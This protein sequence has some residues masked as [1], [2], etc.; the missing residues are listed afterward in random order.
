[1]A[2]AVPVVAEQRRRASL[3]GVFVSWHLLSL[4]APTVAVLWAWAFARAAH[5][6]AASGAIAVLGIGTWLIYVADRLLD[7][8]DGTARTALRERHR[9]H[10]KHRRPFLIV[11]GT[12]AVAL[13]WL[14]VARL[15]ATA[16]REDAAIFAVF[17]VYFV[18]VHLIGARFPRSLAVG[19]IFATA[20]AAPAWSQAELVPAGW[21]AC[22]V[23]FAAL[24]WLNCEAIHAWEETRTRSLRVTTMAACIALAA[25][26]LAVASWT[27]PGAV[28]LAVCILASGLLLLA[29]HLDQRRFARRADDDPALTLRVL[30]DAALLTPILFVLPWRL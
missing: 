23:L 6:H 15:P 22:V 13:L 16:W 12:A 24:C 28:K 21:I 25:A 19:V 4:D 9:F 11:S 27:D 29:L 14:I 10:A 3:P 5:V 18:F 20:S 17:L 30:A 2:I 26:G 7:S 1:V 8:R